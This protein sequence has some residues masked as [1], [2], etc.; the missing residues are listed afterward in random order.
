MHCAPCAFKVLN[1]SFR[2]PHSEF[3]SYR[4]VSAFGYAH[5]FV[6]DANIS[7]KLEDKD[8]TQGPVNTQ[9]TLSD[10]HVLFKNRYQILKLNPRLD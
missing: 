6:D 7:D 4:Q 1:F 10:L 9:L 2:N 5:F 8:L 3:P